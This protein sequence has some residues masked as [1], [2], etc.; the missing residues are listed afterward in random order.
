M[1]S[2]VEP[3]SGQTTERGTNTRDADAPRLECGAN[4]DQLLAQVAERQTPHDK[5]AA[6][7]RLCPHCRAAI[8]ELE[9]LWAPVSIL[10][11]E[12]VSAPAGLVQAV[13]A[14]VRELPR[15]PSYAL[16]AASD[17]GATR[18]AARVIGAIAR[19]A[20]LTV[21]DVSAAAGSGGASGK[22]AVA[23]HGT[24]VGVSGHH[25]VIDMALVL[26]AGAV[27]PTVTT[28]VRQAVIEKIAQLTDLTVT[29]VDISI[30][31]LTS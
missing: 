17:L 30:I 19:R 21:P 1:S 24:A 18:L 3:A 31:D 12:H 15:H 29:A 16:L 28:Q 10:T 5:R 27:I 9:E 11:R 23:R 4:Y 13:M 14:R 20:A 7:Q 25:V 26:A 2:T 6:H 8:A 22:S